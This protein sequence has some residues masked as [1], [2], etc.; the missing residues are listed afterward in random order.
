[1][2]DTRLK[3][4]C[5]NKNVYFIFIYCLFSFIYFCLFNNEYKHS[6][7]RKWNKEENDER[8]VKLPEI[9]RKEKKKKS[10]GNLHSV[11][12]DHVRLR[13]SC[14][15]PMLSPS[16]QRRGE[17]ENVKMVYDVARTTNSNHGSLYS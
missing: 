14:D 17:T 9:K 10:S 7:S 11:S 3:H 8:M 15:G 1:M 13:R 4:R 2:E 5:K 6:E 12:M 16:S